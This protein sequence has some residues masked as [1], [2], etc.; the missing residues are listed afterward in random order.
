MAGEQNG[1]A[2]RDDSEPGFGTADD[3]AAESV[4]LPLGSTDYTRGKKL[5][6]HIDLNNTILVS[7]AVTG[8]GTVAALDSFLTGVTWGKKNK[9]GKWEWLS[10]AASL[11]PP[12]SDAVSYYAQFG[13]TPGFTSVAGRR[14][15]GVLEEHLELLRWPEGTKASDE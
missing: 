2:S 15:K 6:L 14:F 9:H 5:V 7:D 3:P 12:S 4:P 8:Q 10:D 1:T 13:R 11:H